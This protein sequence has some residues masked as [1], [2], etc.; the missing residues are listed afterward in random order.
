MLLSEL[1]D[2]YTCRKTQ[3]IQAK[4]FTAENRPESYLQFM[5]FTVPDKLKVQEIVKY[6]MRNQ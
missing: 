1:M 5:I 4:M 6:R 2:V 3:R